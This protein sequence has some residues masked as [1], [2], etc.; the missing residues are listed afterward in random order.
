MKAPLPPFF[1]AK[2]ELR[3]LG[4]VLVARPGCYSVNWSRGGTAETGFV[5]DDL[6]EVIA[7]GRQMA[8][9]PPPE[10]PP[11]LGPCGTGRRSRRTV[12]I[13]HNR[14]IAARRRGQQ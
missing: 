6:A 8:E 13:R 7:H 4:I 12:M 3:R 5:A 11:M 14:K 2:E 9:S 1:A 10:P